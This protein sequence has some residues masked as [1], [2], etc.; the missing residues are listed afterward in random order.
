MKSY[1]T[2][3]IDGV[4]DYILN[5]DEAKII[6]QDLINLLSVEDD[7]SKL[8]NLKSTNEHF[9]KLIE[10][11]EIDAATPLNLVENDLLEGKKEKIDV[12]V[13]DINEE[14]IGE[15]I[16]KEFCNEVENNSTDLRNMMTESDVDDILNVPELINKKLNINVDIENELKLIEDEL[17]CPYCQRKY[18]TKKILTFHIMSHTNDKKWTCD[19]CD[20]RFKQKWEVAV[21]KRTH[22]APAFEC[23]ICSKKFTQT[24]HLNAHRKKHFSDFLEYCEP[25]QKGF[26][27]KASY[28]NHINVVHKQIWHICDICGC[29]LRTKSA[30]KEHVTTHDQRERKSICEI[31]GKTYLN[32]RTLKHHLKSHKLDPG[33]C[34]KICGKVVSSK[35]VLESHIRTHTGE[36]P[37]QC[38]ICQKTFAAK[39]YLKSHLRTHTGIKPYCCVYC[40]KSFSQRYSLTIHT[41]Y[42]TGERPYTCNICGKNYESKTLLKRHEET[43]NINKID[44]STLFTS[45]FI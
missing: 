45:K 22:F 6:D 30:L 1:I 36:K 21:H 38:D 10:Q 9:E 40:K 41:R 43:H 8:E 19:I 32:D 27:S 37:I 20:K 42:H 23:E 24:S 35:K 25:C 17:K 13:P 44:E 34:C 11:H 16:T 3:Q 29:K 15:L 18:K 39:S 4:D 7:I 31:C 2:K 12:I 26:Y 33:C 5:T 14:E 28:R